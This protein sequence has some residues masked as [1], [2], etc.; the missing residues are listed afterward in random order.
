MTI[1]AGERSSK[2][3]SKG[4]KTIPTTGEVLES[5]V[6]CAFFTGDERASQYRFLPRTRK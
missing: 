3:R 2:K 6:H 5:L 1:T 4:P